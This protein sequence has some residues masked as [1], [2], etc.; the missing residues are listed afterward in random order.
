MR[1]GIVG[2]E[3]SHCTAVA[4][5]LNVERAFGATR[6]VAV[7]GETR[8]FAL[9]AA[10]DGQIPEIVRQPGEMIGRI[11]GVMIDHRDAKYHAAAAIP[12]LDVEIPVFIDKPF[13]STVRE[14]W[15]SLRRARAR[16]TPITSFS[17]LPLQ[18]GFRRVLRPQIRR[19]GQIRIVESV[20]PCDPKSKWGGLY[21]YGIHQVEWVLRAFGP[22]I[23]EALVR[24]GS[25]GNPSAVAI[26]RYRNGG[27][28]VSMTLAAEG[29]CPFALRAIGTK[30][31]VEYVNKFDPNAH[32][33][34][35][36][37]FL[38]MFR[39]GKEPYTAAE[40]LEP[41]AVLQAM[42]TSYRTQRPVRIA[43]L[44]C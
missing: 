24:R 39:T 40:L 25:R 9:K 10:A 13:T 5:T 41:I 35:I 4:R 44:P 36:R 34:G 43:A 16:R 31:S 3:N 21:F 32:R 6:V 37:L 26:L 2:A 27:P 28:I 12:F 1:I 18:S 7:W 14:G 11:D 22:G 30:V 17:I 23:E 38:R 29:S 15:D 20:G 33:E 8:Q 42:R 19:A